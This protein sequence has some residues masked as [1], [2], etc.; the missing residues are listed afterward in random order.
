MVELERTHG[1]DCT[2]TRCVGLQPGN[3]WR[4]GAGNDLAVKHGAYATLKLGPR[5]TEIA[6]ELRPL[7][8]RYRP[9]DE[10]VLQLYAL[11]LARVEAATRVLNYVDDHDADEVPGRLVGAFVPRPDADSSASD[12]QRLRDD[13][14]GWVRLARQLAADLGMT[15]TSRARMGLDVAQTAR[16]L[17]VQDLVAAA[18]LLDAEEPAS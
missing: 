18:V 8:P 11:T 2:C 14:K 3:E 6:D 5:T 7:V 1:A 15:T 13:L 10:P 12:F 16:A 17:N 4:V 9:A